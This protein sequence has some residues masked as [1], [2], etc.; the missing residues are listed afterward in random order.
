MYF[1][2]INAGN[3]VICGREIKIDTK[4]DNNKLP[5]IFFCPKCERQRVKKGKPRA[6]SEDKE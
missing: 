2:I 5:N 6:E 4:R 3:C 1:K